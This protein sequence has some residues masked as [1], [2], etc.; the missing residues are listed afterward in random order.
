MGI[1]VLCC[2]L[3]LDEVYV[4]DSSGNDLSEIALEQKKLPDGSVVLNLVI[5]R[6]G[7]LR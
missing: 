3:K 4:K 5:G 2:T 6:E 1:A 7:H